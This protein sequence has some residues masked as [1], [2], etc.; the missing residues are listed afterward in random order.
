MNKNIDKSNEILIY[1]KKHKNIQKKIT[2]RGY[3]IKKDEINSNI[4]TRI[5]KLLTVQPYVHK[6]YAKFAESF[7]VFYE[8]QE[9]LYLPRYWGLKYIGQ[10][11]EFD[12]ISGDIIDFKCDITPRKEQKIVLKIILNKLEKELGTVLSVACGFGKTICGLYIMC[13]LKARTLIVVHTTVLLNQWIER[14]NEFVPDAKIG[15]I[16][17][18]K[19][20][21]EGRNVVICMLQTLCSENK[22]Y[23]KGFFDSFNLSIW[24]ECFPYKHF[25]TTNKGCFH[26]GK[27]YEMWKNNEELPL[28]KSY[29]VEKKKCEMKKMTYAW[30]KECKEIDELIKITFYC[31]ISVTCT[32]NHKFLMMDKG[33][34]RLKYVEARLLQMKVKGS[35]IMAQ[36]GKLKIKHIEYIKN[37]EEFLYDI[38]VEDNHNFLISSTISKNSPVVHNCL[39]FNECILT[40]KGPI[41]I[42]TLYEMWKNNR[43]L[44]LIKSFNEDTKKYEYRRMVRGFRNINKKL[45]KISFGKKKISCTP[46]HKINTPHGYIPA[47]N[48][49]IGDLVIAHYIKE[50]V[51][52]SCI[53]KALNKD[54]MQILLGSYFGDGNIQKTPSDR[55]R[56]R[57]THG[58]EQK[59]YCQFKAK[60]FGQNI[61]EVN[62]NPHGKGFGKKDN[63]GYKFYSR[64]IDLE[65]EIPYKKIGCPDW[66]LDKMDARGIAIWMMDDGYYNK[67]QKTIKIC[68]MA[69]DEQTHKKFVNYFNKFDIDVKYYCFKKTY[70]NIK[71]PYYSLRFNQSNTLKL[72][73]LIKPYIH[74][75]MIYK[76]GLEVDFRE[77]LYSWDSKFLD[78]GYAKISKIEERINTGYGRCKTAYVYNIEV[79]EH[80]NYVVCSRINENGVLFSNCHHLAAPTFSRALPLICT[81]YLLGLS[82][83]PKRADKLENVFY[84]HLGDIGYQQKKGENNKEVIVKYVNYYSDTYKEVKRWNGSYNLPKMVEQILNNEYRRKF[85][86]TQIE[87]L[88]KTNRKIL[89]L[90]SRKSDLKEMKERIDLLELSKNTENNELIIPFLEPLFPDKICEII[91]R[92]NYQLI[93]TGYYVGGMKSTE[94][95]E[96]AK[97]DII[98]GTYQLVSEGLDISTLDTLIMMLPRKQVEQVVG[99]ILRGKSKYIPLVID[100][101]DIFSIYT[102]QGNFRARYYR[103]CKYHQDIFTITDDDYMKVLKDFKET[104]GVKRKK[105]R[106][107]NKTIE[108]S[109]GTLMINSDNE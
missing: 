48:L 64:L 75:T 69:F 91:S 13:K 11:N 97:C 40:Q 95:A 36:Y 57:I 10:P 104:E 41:M 55:Y 62:L 71:K 51:A 23:P 34:R 3:I 31:K 103:V 88:S 44:P 30:E 72:I 107:K 45:L 79:E 25:V 90:S 99:R 2:R 73:N 56:L 7:T 20:D 83:T 105:T 14:I 58:K 4:I 32:P 66:I 24:D 42:G 82:A 43:E 94:L 21:I 100:I 15:I 76:I 74:Q 9:C 8:N 5:K 1:F 29:N 84:W 93:T 101:C 19:I 98:F 108:E 70:K 87:Y 49:K 50:D 59:D 67:K 77:E 27:L 16:K 22:C 54:Q 46:N 52:E 17:G 78:Y 96:S 33:T 81:K 102:N 109:F 86:Q 65:N 12:I 18:N 53:S 26:I 37:E 89:A 85:I 38:E 63:M 80:H 28:I 61:E 60:M 6:D 92:Y 68:S 35:I 39:T 47:E 106:K